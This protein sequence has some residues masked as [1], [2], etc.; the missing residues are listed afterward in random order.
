MPPPHRWI[1]VGFALSGAAGLMHE[2]AWIRRATLVFG[3][4]TY[5]LSTVLAVFFGGLA[6]GSALFGRRSRRDPRPLVTFA[7]LEGGVALLALASPAAFALAERAYGAAYGSWSPEALVALRVGLVALVLLPPT[8]LMGGTL[9]LACAHVVRER[10]RVARGVGVLYAGNTLG[11]LVGCALAGLVLVPWLGV[12]ATLAAGAALNLAAAACAWRAR[13]EPLE[14]VEARERAPAGA[15]RRHRPSSDSL[16]A[17]L[18]FA[19]GFAVLGQEVLWSRFLALILRVRVTTVTL[20]LCCVLAGIAI[21][22]AL[23]ARIADG[24][25]RKGRLYGALHALSGLT[26]AFLMT[27]PPGMW[28]GIG[29]DLPALALLLTPG[30]VLAGMG[31]PLA[32]RM[33]THDGA[34]GA[35]AGAMAAASTFGGILGSLA[36]GFA[37]L[38]WL[39]LHAGMLVTSGVSVAAGAVAWLALD[40]GPPRARAAWAAAAVLAWIAAPLVPGVRLPEDHLAGSGALVD[41]VEGLESNV[42]VVRRDGALHLEIDRTWQGRTGRSHQTVAAHLPALLHGAP[43]S[44]LVVGVGVGQTARS[45]LAHDSVEDLV[46]VDIEPAL[47]DV[48]REHFDGAWLDDPRVTVLRADGRQHL[49]HGDATYDVVSLELGQLFRPGVSDFYTRELYAGAA[50]RLAPGGIVCQFLPIPF[51]SAPDFR[52]AVRT[53][54]D[55]FP[56]CALWYNTSELL[57]LGFEDELA[58]DVESIAAA[59]D[60]PELAEELRFSLW[61]GDAH[62]LRRPQVLLSGF[63]AGPRGLA[64]LSRGAPLLV[65]DRPRLAH[66]ARD[67]REAEPSDPAVVALLRK[68]LEPLAEY[69]TLAPGDELRA[70]IERLR[71]QNLAD[72]ATGPAVRAAD[73]ALAGGDHDAARRLLEEVLRANP[74]NVWAHRTLGDLALE[75][76]RPADARAA[77]EAALQLGPSDAAAHRGLAFAL[78]RGGDPAAAVP[79]YRAALAVDPDDAEAHNN[80]GAAL[81]QGGDLEGAARH[82][83]AALRARPDHA[84]ARRNLEQARRVLGGG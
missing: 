83:E 54:A 66:T 19:S 56:R 51:L 3:A 38:P 16:V 37:V 30:A 62:E 68:H 35:R 79:H 63:L 43:R 82:F 65:D 12:R 49:L 69:A 17:L 71:E 55:V 72:L 75:A 18:V 32:V 24:V 31:F 1:L 74:D 25:A 45:F 73:E 36:V 29:P 23:A 48:I 6:I 34:V 40:E 59:L 60:D 67:G 42:A 28:R 81:A 20:V 84:D 77:F 61:G 39:G 21:G 10:T 57:L 14:P 76:N 47:F 7:V 50:E 2:V 64:D 27:R 22:S 26:V 41:H 78:H 4:T 15:M 33:V 58:I 70:R 13:G 80:L 5:A 52:S 9:P 46:C 44:V 8:V 11:A 53:F